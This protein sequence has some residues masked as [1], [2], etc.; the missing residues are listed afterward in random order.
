MS[1]IAGK[2][3]KPE[4]LVRKLLFARGLRYRKNVKSLRGKPDIVL[5]KYKTV[6]FI[7]GCFWHGHKGCPKSKLPDTR[8]EFWD[9]KISEN[10]N[11]DKADVD[12]LNKKKWKVISVWQC[13]ID[14]VIKRNNRVEL[15]VSEITRYMNESCHV[16]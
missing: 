2:E 13:E 5:P 14:N 3:T 15:L 7:H 9:K 1:H 8:R 16:S 11:R 4:V 6:V 12:V 10:M